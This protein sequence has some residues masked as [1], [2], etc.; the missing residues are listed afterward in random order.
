[1][2]SIRILL[3]LLLVHIAAAHFGHAAEN[4]HSHSLPKRAAFAPGGDGVCHT[5]IIQEGETCAKLA[6]RYQITTSNI[7]TWNTGAWGWSG[8]ANIKQ[9][10]FVCLSS[11]TFPMPV[12]LP[13]AICGPQ[14]PGTGRPG[15]YSDLASLNPCPS[16]Q[17]VSSVIIQI[18]RDL[19]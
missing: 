18:A 10:D 15:K 12:A 16:N 2:N 19:F 13:R 5:Y 14:V 6:E 9:G 7:E 17:C 3:S 11:G 4:S 1:M 8:C